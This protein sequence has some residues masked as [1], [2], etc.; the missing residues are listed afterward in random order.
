MQMKSNETVL[1]RELMKKERV[2]SLG[3]AGR[4]DSWKDIGLY[5]NR[6][7]RTHYCPAKF[8]AVSLTY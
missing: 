1:S 4:L 8:R 7:V 2:H 6:N 3:D 5:L